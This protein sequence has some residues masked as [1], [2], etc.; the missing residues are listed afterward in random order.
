M[1]D[2]VT[3]NFGSVRLQIQILNVIQFSSFAKWD[4]ITSRNLMLGDA[5]IN[6]VEFF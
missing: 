1:I 5:C 6:Y 2:I 3:Q 4:E